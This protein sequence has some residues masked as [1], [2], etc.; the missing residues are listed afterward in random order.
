MPRP[1]ISLLTDFGHQDPYVGV[2]KGV[3]A[4]RCRDAL[5]IDLCHE[6]EPQNVAQ[7]AYLLHTSYGYFPEGTVHVIVV[8]PGVGSERR[9]ICVQ[10]DGHLFL[11][12]DNGVLGPVVDGARPDVAVEVSNADHFLANV[13]CTFHGRDVF[14]PTAAALA[15]GVE[16]TQL[17]QCVESMVTLDAPGPE[18]QPDGTLVGTIVHVDRFGNLV[19]D[20]TEDALRQHCPDL[21][22]A[23]VFVGSA[24]IRGVAR[25]YSDVEV[26]GWVALMGSTG[27]LEISVNCGNAA[28]TAQCGIGAAATVERG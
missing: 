27:R 15:S 1:V 9:V 16:P 2:M 20:I 28:E 8:D 22:S 21:A 7:A 10:A 18:V 6:V 24:S 14:A 5:V 19:T 13:S 11:A 25:C 12:P 23:H 4:S 26:G 17:G 3:I